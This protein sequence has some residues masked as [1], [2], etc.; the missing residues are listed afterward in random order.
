MSAE[1]A[2]TGRVSKTWKAVKKWTWRKWLVALVVIA[3]IAL[4]VFFGV[5]YHQTQNKNKLLLNPQIAAQQQVADAV[6]AVGKLVQLPSNETPTLATV[7]DA[8]KLKSQAFFANAQNGDKVLIYTQ[9]KEAILYR[10]STNKI[11]QIAPVNI[12][13]NSSTATPA[14]PAGQ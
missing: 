3:A 8:S 9:A 6:S 1:V 2:K 4:A 10:P 13:D 12:G 11:I 7:T 5:K 14:T